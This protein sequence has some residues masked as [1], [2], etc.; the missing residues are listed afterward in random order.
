MVGND[1]VSLDIADDVYG[2]Q[3]KAQVSV[4]Y[5]NTVKIECEDILEKIVQ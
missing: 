5:P 2:E 1:S 4:T 3:V